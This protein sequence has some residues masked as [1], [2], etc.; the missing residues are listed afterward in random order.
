MAGFLERILTST[1][2]ICSCDELRKQNPP[3]IPCNA[4]IFEIVFKIRGVGAVSDPGS[5]KF[6]FVNNIVL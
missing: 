4:L 6:R 2:T 5:D 1:Y 3:V